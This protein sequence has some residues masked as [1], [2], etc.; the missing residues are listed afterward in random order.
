[1]NDN[2]ILNFSAAVRN[3]TEGT[4]ILAK[5]KDGSMTEFE[6]L[7]RVG[8][9][10]RGGRTILTMRN[11]ATSA[12]MHY[13]A[14][15]ILKNLGTKVYFCPSE[16][17]VPVGT[18]GRK[19]ESKVVGPSISPNIAEVR[20]VLGAALA[21]DSVASVVLVEVAEAVCEP[22]GEPEMVAA[23]EAVMESEEAPV[24]A[25]SELSV[26]VPDGEFISIADMLAKYSNLD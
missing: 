11:L 26:E 16:N 1:M 15:E 6:V 4:L 7:E 21:M 22:V 20:Q 2:L 9:R 18:G 17:L 12:L 19:L 8:H 13:G 25:P 3:S 10:G 23:L 24:E 14:E 5:N